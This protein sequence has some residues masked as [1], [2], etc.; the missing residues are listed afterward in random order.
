MEVILLFYKYVAVSDPEGIKKW[1]QKICADLELKGRVILAKEGINATL[2][3]E[4]DRVDRYIALM[5]V[6]PLFSGIDYKLSQG[7]RNDFPRL[8]IKVKDEI[9]RLGISST[10]LTPKQGGV[11]LSPE[12]A[13]TLL[14]EKPEDLVVLDARNQC[15]WEIGRFEGAINPGITYF[16]ELPQYIDNTIEQFKD[17][18]VLLYC[19]G[20]VRCERATAYLK[21]KN[22]AKEVYQVKGGIARYIEQYP[23]GFFRGKNYVFDGRISVVANNDVLGY[24]YICQQSC[25]EYTN[26]E[27]TRCNRHYISC[28][29][30]K[31][32]LY[33][34][35]STECIDIV[36]QFPHYA[37]L[38]SKTM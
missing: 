37:Q 18:K 26:C 28:V 36:R 14:Q 19:T 17:K 22:V 27:N 15:E 32:K 4:K 33:G 21:Q 10:D 20:G 2:S 24:C 3:G 11:H 30:C 25:D 7:A 8:S 13:H 34:F 23:N 31:E 16:R 9:V 12:E 35:C 29:S 38:Q 5:E 6:H 1:Q